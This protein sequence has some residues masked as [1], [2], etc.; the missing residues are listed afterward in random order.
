[1]N[2][3][4]NEYLPSLERV[5]KK[6]FVYFVLIITFVPCVLM[7]CFVSAAPEN[8]EQE[9]F[10]N[11]VIN[12][13]VQE[14]KDKGYTDVKYILSP[15]VQE[16]GHKYI[17][18]DYE[19]D[20]S[21]LVL[22][23]YVFSVKYFVVSNKKNTVYFKT[24]KEKKDFIKQITKYQ[25]NDYV[26][27]I[28]WERIG[29]ETEQKQVN[30]IITKAKKD[31][32][33]YLAKQ[34]QKQNA[35]KKKTTKKVIYTSGKIDT[36]NAIVRY[37]IQ[38]NGNPYVSGGTSLTRG[39]DC[40]GFTQSIYKH[41]GVSIARTPKQQAKQGKA[42]SFNE[43]KAGDLV[44]YSGNGGK[45]ITHV[46]LY[47]GGGQIIHARTPKKGIGITTVNINMVKMAA[48]RII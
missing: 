28:M 47:I 20:I 33:N 30:N 23:E 19:I 11:N 8:T 36:T 48:R 35:K 9:I 24:E 14:L 2:E 32:E 41:F 45:S 42:V 22:K 12:D 7:P 21:K 40:S 13:Y 1:M 4:N 26:E 18:N 39:A 3:K 10:V 34:R 43:L 17:L 46:A 5:L 15:L 27:K 37:A 31:Y 38:F 16:L 44:F 6:I 25:K 29:I